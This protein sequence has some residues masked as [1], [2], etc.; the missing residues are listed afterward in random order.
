MVRFEG[1]DAEG[2]AIVRPLTDA[3]VAELNALIG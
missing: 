3:E 2:N 1:I